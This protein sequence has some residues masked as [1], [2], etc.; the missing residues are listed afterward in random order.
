MLSIYPILLI[1]ILAK[2]NCRQYVYKGVFPETREAAT[3]LCK[4]GFAVGYS[5]TKVTPLWVAQRIDP[6]T[7]SRV[8]ERPAFH[9]DHS[10]PFNSQSSISDFVGSGFD[11]G[12]L[13]PF[14]D[15]SFS[16]ESA[17]DSMSLTNIVPQ[18]PSHNQGI[19]KSLEAEVRRSARKETVFVVSGPLFEDETRYLKRRIPIP[20]SLWKVMISPRN[21][22][23]ATWVIS[24][25]PVESRDTRKYKASL[26]KLKAL[27]IDV[28]PKSKLVEV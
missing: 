26:A 17:K 13:A 19:W 14:E 25:Q 22:T 10:V 23:V 1:P 3:V 6:N 27:G 15:M 18:D 2:S 12:H 16:I 11:K 8:T 24:N 28:A 4:T 5:M 9:K 20:S 21:E 7:R